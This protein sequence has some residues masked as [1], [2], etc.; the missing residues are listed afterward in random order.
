MFQTVTPSVTPIDLVSPMRIAEG[1]PGQVLVSD[2]RQNKI[3]ALDEDTLA[4]LWSF[5]VQGTPMAVGFAAGLVLVG[6]ATTHNVE[7]YRLKGPPTAPTLEF[8]FNLGM[9]P[10][11]TPG[12]IRT[13]SDVAI[14]KDAR[15]AFVLDSGDH[16]VKIFTL[17]GNEFSEIPPPD[18]S[19]PLLSPTAIAIDPVR[20]EVVVSDYGNPNG[21]FSAAVAASI[22][23]YTYSG[24]FLARFNGN[25]GTTD[26]QFAR[27]QG[28]AIDSQGHIF[29]AESVRGQ[30]FEFDRATGSVANKL[31]AFGNGPGELMLPL[32]LLIDRKSGDLMVTNNMLGRIEILSAATGGVQ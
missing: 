3:V 17:D 22:A 11:D 29:M 26:V 12:N 21:Y 20:Q 8:Q 28:L 15:L 9:T 23:I 5:D 16:R 7:V 27:P 13:P 6:N 31:G 24:E 30:I 18:S 2:S 14:D 19:A 1:P 4:P 32:D 25:V 10:P